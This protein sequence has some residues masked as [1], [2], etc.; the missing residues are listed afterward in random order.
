MVTDIYSQQQ[1]TDEPRATENAA[2]KWGE[3]A[4]EATENDTDKALVEFMCDGPSSVQQ[5]GHWLVFAQDVSKRDQHTLDEDVKMYFYT[6]IT[7]MDTFIACWD[8]KMFYASAR[9]Y[10]QVHHYYQNQVIKAWA[11]PRKGMI[12]IKGEE[13]RPYS[14][15]E[16]LCPAF[17]SYVSGHSTVSGGCGEALR[18]FTGDDAFGAEAEMIPGSYTEIDSAYYGKPVTLKFPTFT[19]AAEMAGISRVMG[20][21]HIQAYNLAGLQ[22]GRDV[23]AEAWKF[24][25]RHLGNVGIPKTK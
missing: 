16:F 15:A 13:W 17:P 4:L 14:P 9:L 12:E 5:A 7:A 6:E 21:Y 1:E 11:G 20:G 24:Y 19:E 10:A 25:N 22:L 2:Y 23:A 8:A 3:M 18:L